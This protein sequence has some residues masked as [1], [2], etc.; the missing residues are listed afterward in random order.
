MLT[1]IDDLR[2]KIR[3]L[4]ADISHAADIELLDRMPDEIGSFARHRGQRVDRE[5]L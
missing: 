4:I 3:S 5:Y 2:V 1:Q